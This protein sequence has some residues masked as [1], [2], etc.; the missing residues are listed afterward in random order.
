MWQSIESGPAWAR[1]MHAVKKIEHIKIFTTIYV[2]GIIATQVFS[3]LVIFLVSISKNATD[4]IYA[5]K[6]QTC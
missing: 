4:K 3:I 6:S 1:G 5:F 2:T